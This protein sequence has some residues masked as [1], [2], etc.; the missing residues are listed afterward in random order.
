MVET[1]SQLASLNFNWRA[2][3]RLVAIAYLIV[4]VVTTIVLDDLLA[5]VMAAVVLLGLA[6]LRFRSRWFGVALLCLVFAEPLIWTLSGAVSNILGGERFV[7]IIIP[8]A[9]ATLS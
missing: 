8:S 3:L 5:A 9:L 7:A 6:L 1:T 4:L 2:S